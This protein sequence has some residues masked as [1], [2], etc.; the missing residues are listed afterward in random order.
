M[1][2][3]AVTALML[4]SCSDTGAD[5][6][7]AGGS[8]PFVQDTF[9]A[10]DTGAGDAAKADLKPGDQAT[11]NDISPSSDA[12]PLDLSGD[13]AGALADSEADSEPADTQIAQGLFGAPCVE[14]A[15]CDSGFC[16]EGSAGNVCGKLCQGSCPAGWTCANLQ[17]GGADVTTVCVPSFARLCDPCTGAQ[18]CNAPG[19]SGG[20]CLA[21]ES[22][23]GS[24]CA[25]A[26]VPGKPGVCP[27]GYA[28]KP[29][30]GG[31]VCLPAS[32][33]CT[34]SP[35]AI[36]KELITPCDNSNEFGL[37]V[38]Q[39]SC[40]GGS[41]SAC[42]APQPAAEACNGQDDDCNGSTD[43][44]AAKPCETKNEFG[45]CK[46][47]SKGCDGANVLCNAAT[48]AP[49][50]CNGQD[51][52]CDGQTD[53]GLCEDG[54]V[55]TTG[56]CNSDGSCQQNPAA[57][58]AC[59][60]GNVCTVVDQCQGGSCQ[61]SQPLLCD[62]AN[63]CTADTC[64]P[65]KGCVTPSAAPGTA[66]A[67]DGNPCTADQC[68]D[69]SCQH[70]DAAPGTACADDGNPC[71][72]DQCQ[73]KVCQH[74]EAAAGAP[75]ADDGNPCSD[76]KCSGG[77]CQH[78]ASTKG[79]GC[80]DDGDLCTVDQCNGAGTCSHE[81]AKGQCKIG[82][83]C[84]A[85][86]SI[87]PANPCQTCDPAVSATNWILK[88]GLVCSDGNPCTV[89]DACTA[90]QCKGSQKS[91]T[92]LD[93]ACALGQCSPVTGACVAAPK[94]GGTSCSD[95][96][97]CTESDVCD[98]VGKCA[99]KAVDCSAMSTTCTTGVCS[100]GQ[101]L[102]QAKTNGL[103][104]SDN[105]PCTTG[106]VCSV[107]KCV[108]AALNCSAKA[109][110]C[111]DGTC[112]NGTC[113]ATPKAGSPS[114]NDASTCTTAD[115]CVAGKCT[116]KST[117]DTYEPNSSSSPDTLTTKTD[118]DGESSLTATVSPSGDTDWYLFQAED[119][120]GCTIKPSARLDTMSADYDVCVYFQCGGG[121]VGADVI[122]CVDGTSVS[123]GPSGSYGCC[124]KNSGTISD[125]AKFS[126][127][128]SFLGAGSESGKVWISVTPK[129][130]A[131]CGS[132]KL[133]WSA[134]N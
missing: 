111:N 91:C 21:S 108:G 81:V 93:S 72:L 5:G 12:D 100:G 27:G 101:C 10:F 104:C 32:G 69:K 40:K 103:T 59:D 61:G 50:T 95:G 106:D 6:S 105:N 49:E 62:D 8:G 124:S 19:L 74:P 113:Q 121:K 36:A 107:G 7:P 99:G 23:G 22:G 18:D 71:T 16:V 17:S 2:L 1:A 126:P 92:S 66:C 47:L 30:G 134:K 24:F 73:G 44:T 57:G 119:K 78:P 115:V 67:D 118:C 132:Y 85:A 26:C 63:P 125:F 46:G 88:D 110:Q 53:E 55:C 97:T 70:L 131:I 41:L 34:C 133:S 42:S 86:G 117:A 33:Q 129:S 90:G 68:L 39:R 83:Q 82:G 75:C 94:A 114:C 112:V 13:E 35:S 56:T 43:D 87:N 77:V 89:N 65:Q 79:T 3:S 45:T 128:C 15:D 123:G 51:D 58:A 28:C 37:C 31:N 116:G 64:D 122:S 9:A 76:D 48:P 11:G 84:I 14:G 52:D 127:S 38:G 130:G 120:T 80:P 54:N 109:D 25:A 98:G 29:G 60:D 20:I 102:A 96:N 4:A